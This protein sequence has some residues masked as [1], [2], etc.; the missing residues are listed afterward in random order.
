MSS[1]MG[2]G[3]L[4]D[5]CAYR[6]HWFHVLHAL[7]QRAPISFCHKHVSLGEACDHLV[8]PLPALSLV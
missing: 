8:E 1:A 5:R 2:L 4:L 7:Q 3:L 6:L